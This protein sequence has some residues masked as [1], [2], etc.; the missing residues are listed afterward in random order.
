MCFECSEGIEGSGRW[1]Q[2]CSSDP[3]WRPTVVLKI[4][5]GSAL[6]GLETYVHQLL[7]QFC[8]RPF[9]SSGS[10]CL[11]EGLILTWLPLFQASCLWFCERSVI[12]QGGQ[13]RGWQSSCW[14]CPAL[15]SLHPSGL[16]SSRC[17][18]ASGHPPSELQVQT[19]HNLSLFFPSDPL[20]LFHGRSHEHSCQM[21]PLQ[22][23]V[24]PPITFLL[25]KFN[26]FPT[27]PS[28]HKMKPQFLAWHLGLSTF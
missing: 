22:N 28:N 4:L 23:N 21:E 18:P 8:L 14:G 3:P 27:C 24:C 20:S 17:H 10:L 26:P 16:P 9:A 11:F 5:G 2:P 25:R 12:L 1:P 13:G 6:T 19:P 7:H 15:A